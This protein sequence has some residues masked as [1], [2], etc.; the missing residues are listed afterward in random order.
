MINTRETKHFKKSVNYFQPEFSHIYIE[1]EALK[2][3]RTGEILLSF[4]S[5]ERIPI[6]DYKQVFNRSNQNILG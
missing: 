1:D 3:E 5:A 6:T 2:W 4:P